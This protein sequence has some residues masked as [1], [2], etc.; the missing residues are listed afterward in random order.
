MAQEE[1]SSAGVPDAAAGASP[2]RDLRQDERDLHRRFG[3]Q[4]NNETWD[5]LD[6]TDSRPA[7]T[8]DAPEEVK[9]RALYG[10][11]A[12]ARHWAEV[13][14]AANRA[15]GEYLIARVAVA[16]GLP[17]TALRH[18]RKCLALVQ[19]H[20]GEMADWDIPFAHEALARAL[21]ASGDVRAAREHRATAVRLSGEVAG[22]KDRQILNAEL[23][24]GP[25]HG[26]CEE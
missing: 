23:D 9:D 16:I 12:S 11:Y 14:T 18:A 10:A 21:A 15:R 22:P 5:L 8:P 20:P 1:A 2:P 3:V 24:R 6:G 13:G 25:W 19:S 7:I 17:D 4:L 26:I